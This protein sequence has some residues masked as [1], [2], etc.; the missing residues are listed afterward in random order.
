V[1]FTLTEK[2]SCVE[3][4][5]RMRRRVYPRWVHQ[6]KMNKGTAEREIALMQAILDEDLKEP[7]LL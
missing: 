2:R 7:T 5:I 3:R 4:E 1:S 6:G